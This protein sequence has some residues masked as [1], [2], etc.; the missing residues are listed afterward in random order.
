MSKSQSLQ[1]V[2]ALAKEKEKKYN[3]L[4]A[5]ELYEQALGAV[6]KNDFLKKGKIRE[7]I[8][9]CFHRAAMQVESRE[10]FNG[11]MERAVE[12]YED[13]GRTFEKMTDE[14]K[15][16]WMFR[17]EAVAKYLGY[18][19]TSVPSEKRRLLDECL[20]LEEKALTAFWKLGN[21]LEYGRTYNELS[22]VF[23]FRGFLEWDRQT[24]KSI[25]ERGLKWGEKAVA[26]LPE[27]GDLFEIAW[28]YFTLATCLS[29]WGSFGIFGSFIAELEEIEEN[30]LKTV[31]CLNKAVDLSEKVGDAFLLGLS[32]LWLG[33]NMLFGEE[34]LKHFEKTLECGKR[35]RD[36]F[37]IGASLDFLAFDTYWKT[38]TIEDPDRRWKLAEDA[39]KF[40]DESQ[41]YCSII[42][43]MPPRNGAIGQPAGYAEYHFERAKYR[44][45]DSKKRLELLEKAEKEG[46]EALQLA[47]SS[48]IPRVVWC[49][50]HVLSKILNE[51]ARID[52]DITE[53][54]RRL[55]KALEYRERS[56][57][58]YGRID[59]FD[60]WNQG[61][62][63][64]YFA[65]IKVELANNEPDFDDKRRLLEEAVL[66]KEKSL[67]LID[68]VMPYL[69]RMGD[70]IR[71]SVLRRY[72]ET[73]ATL[74]AQL[75]G[76]TNKPEH[77]RKAIEI[78]LRAIES[79]RKLDMISLMAESYWKIAKAH[80]TLREHLEAAENFKHASEGYIQTSE[81][82]PQLKDFYQDHAF[83]MKAWNEIEKAKHYHARQK[84]G[85]AKKHYEK[86]ANL[87]K[88]SKS[89]KYL[90]S[91]YLA[92]VQLEHGE[93]LSRNEQSQVA[94]QAFRKAAELFRKAKRTLQVEL[95]KKKNED[96]K[97]LA[98][99][100]IKASDVRE[101]YCLGR[102]ALEEA[103]ILDRKGDHA[104]SSRK[105]GSATEKFQ[106]ATDTTE[107]ES[108]RQE[109]KPIVFLCRAWQM[110]TRAEAEASP[111]LYLE[112][113]QLF[114]EAKEHSLNEQA[115]VLALGHSCFCKALEA[116]TRFEATRD[117]TL[118]SAATQ[119]LTS[120][121]NYYVRA[122]FKNASEYAKATQRLFDAYV[123]M[124]NAKKEADL[125]KK[126]RYYMTAE[127]VLQT[128]ADS[129]MK[130][131]H[132]EKSEQVQRLLES[133]KEERELA[134]SLTEVL[135]APTI[136]STTTS[137]ST[138]TPTHEKAVGLER[139]EHTNIQAH[140]MT[141]EEVTIG[142]ELE[143]RLDLVNVAKDFGLLVRIDDLV[144]PSF[145]I[146]TLPS[147]YRI[148]N[149][150]ID[151]KGR[152]LEPLKVESI[153]LCLQATEAGVINL[154]PQVVYVDEAGKFGTCRPEP[155]SITVHPKLTF[156]FK[157]NAAQKVFDFLTS[158]F[159]EDYMRRRISLEKSGWRTLMQIIKH[160]KVSKSSVYGTGGRRGP[161][162][163]ELER[164][165]FVETRVF[166]GERGRG[167]K[168][169]KMRISYEKETIKRHIDQ[170][171]MKIKEK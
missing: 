73:Y 162:I 2:L 86:A 76:L 165:G 96:E 156:E 33:M 38:W 42:S 168:I 28:A 46:M 29:F 23:F 97:N 84:Y 157:T 151:M 124:D 19:V 17:C 121:A 89:W 24:S 53:K 145:K 119:H 52:S 34:S 100:L 116:G 57:G 49:C 55:E 31:R 5:A 127:K 160:A 66:S 77:L 20:E 136:A 65:D 71:F 75:Y 70:R 166:P 59:P 64:N 103:K 90:A 47:E 118:H 104:A 74:L 115:K 122:G 51:R 43:F 135:H 48:G 79:A 50:F 106:K 30:R 120:A 10:E 163:S 22:L 154:S 16:A 14:Q 133:V 58:M 171:V 169:S 138:P 54:R 134:M 158:S 91:N 140:L 78:S 159:V 132:P 141:S 88:S 161:A 144:S 68:K 37:L 80:D 67:K 41:H 111:N 137:F 6:G 153:K 35:T 149:G 9:F 63:Q 142:E 8:G 99:R 62:D 131:K 102:I 126:T 4:K 26:A 94:I 13:A 108:D 7:R 93:D 143:V 21:M 85:Q 45:I 146:T 18:W 105:Y 32:H 123:Y 11:R 60:Y 69:E 130:A 3:W 170:R 150:S 113:S 139:F 155:V 167:G 109:L 39:M 128:S 83:Y 1:R 56:I 147:Q 117:T 148:E 112:A 92:W 27:L 125:E 95:D 164:R 36:N 87:H 81:K 72:E 40:Y 12:A 61:V 82:I 98:K 129:Y 101:E 44:E 25:V 114:D 15:T 107:H 152:R 110:M